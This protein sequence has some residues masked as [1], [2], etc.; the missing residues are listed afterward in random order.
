MIDFPV[1]T[2]RP[3]EVLP[4][5]K[6]RVDVKA[7][8]GADSKF[9]ALRR[10]ERSSSVIIRHSQTA[11]SNR[12]QLSPPGRCRKYGNGTGLARGRAVSTDGP[13][14]ERRMTRAFRYATI[15]VL[16]SLTVSSG[17][18]AAT[19]HS[20]STPAGAHNGASNEDIMKQCAQQAQQ[21]W[22]GNGQE[23]KTPREYFYRACTFDHGLQ[24]P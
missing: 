1:R 21:R 4:K 2:S 7:R 14:W 19:R 10:N 24:N 22:P 13:E 5:V 18:Y 17:A 23:A 8:T 11:H 15:A 12:R 9:A 6:A 20:T 3:G 16:A